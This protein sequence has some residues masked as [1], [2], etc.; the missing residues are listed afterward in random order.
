MKKILLSVFSVF[1]VLSIVGCGSNKDG[2]YNSFVNEFG[3]GDGLSLL[4]LVIKKDSVDLEVSYYTVETSGF[5][6]VNS[7][8]KENNESM[9]GEINSSKKTIEFP[10]E[11]IKMTYIIEDDSIVLKDEDTKNTII[12]NVKGSKEYDENISK[13]KSQE[14]ELVSFNQS[15]NEDIDDEVVDSSDKNFDE[16]SKKFDENRQERSEWLVDIIDRD[17]KEKINGK[18][19]FGDFSSSWKGGVEIEFKEDGTVE[20][21]EK[22]Q[23][24][25]SL[26]FDLKYTGT[27]EV[28]KGTLISKLMKISDASEQR[29]PV[30][31]VG[32]DSYESYYQI[33]NSAKNESFEPITEDVYIPIKFDLDITGFNLKDNISEKKS[34]TMLISYHNNVIQ[35]KE[36]NVFNNVKNVNEFTRN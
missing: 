13:Y 24:P 25:E 18:W 29:S 15:S 14:T 31:L 17:L 35:I 8:I 26:A 28:D 3:M 32:I 9:K 4:N 11:D 30:D 27:Y 20:I 12:F 1:F 34:A 16:D 36:N 22:M 21:L 7:E 23:V 2:E 10:N 5:L 6:G 19:K 33:V